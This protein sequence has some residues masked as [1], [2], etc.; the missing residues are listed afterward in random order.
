MKVYVDTYTRVVLTIVAVMLTVVA[1]G[2]WLEMPDTVSRAEAQL[3][4]AGMQ[5]LLMV[6]ELGKVRVEVANLA[7]LLRSGEAKFQVVEVELPEL[8]DAGADAENGDMP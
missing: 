8:K 5:R 7:K 3:P 6:E 2:L 4:D 1:A